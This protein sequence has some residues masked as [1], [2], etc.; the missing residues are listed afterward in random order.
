M[1]FALLAVQVPV[2]LADAAMLA[3][4]ERGSE[5]AAVR[6]LSH[7]IR[8]AVRSFVEEAEPRTVRAERPATRMAA[9]APTAVDQIERSPMLDHLGPTLVLALP[10]PGR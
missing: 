9:L 5:R 2:V 1:A 10:P 7:V 6:Q 4:S 8:E 3:A